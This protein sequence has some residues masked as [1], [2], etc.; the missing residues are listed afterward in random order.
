MQV[1]VFTAHDRSLPEALAVWRRAEELGFDAVGVVDSPMIMRE[2]LVSLTAL[3]LS[4]T[5]VRILPSVLNTLTRDPT[6]VAGAYLGL[7]DLVGDRVT[8][9]FGAG[10]SST[11]GVGL[12]TARLAHM[13]E[14]IAAVRGLVRGEAVTYQ[15]R[16]LRGAWQAAQEVRARVLMSAHGP[17]ALAAAGAVA[18]GVISGFGM[19]PETVAEAERLV[20]EGAERAGRDPSG[21]E[22]W[23]VAYY[24]PAETLQ[25]GFVHANGGSAAV[26]SRGGLAGKLVPRHLEDAVR[27]VG[28][29]WTLDTHGRANR[30]ALEVAEETGSLDYLT[31][32]GGGLIGPVDLPAAL[33]DLAARGVERLLVVALGHD[34]LRLV[35]D[36]G[37][38]L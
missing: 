33:R 3:A 7:H 11:H 22:I 26:L 36:L 19:L 35:E 37:A 8:L 9:A 16:T 10:D 6:V 25:E 4:T 13:R 32:R 28:A 31:Q 30:R 27:A 38:A 21:I 12:G 1:G 18:D 14:F 34:K 29:T 15:G 2:A 5:R 24:C 17:R 23:H 20:R